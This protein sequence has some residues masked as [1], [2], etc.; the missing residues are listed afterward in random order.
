MSMQR[1]AL[2]ILVCAVGIAGLAFGARQSFGLFMV[3]V[4]ES[5]GWGRE[6]LSLVFAV[7]ALLNGL[8]A[9]F[10]GAV[11]DKWGTGRTVLTG[12][13]LYAAGLVVMSQA[14]SLSTR[15]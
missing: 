6:S 11:S 9:P 15:K 12:G 5:L 2:L 7:Q 1:L 10:A 4:S 13:A 3:P 8:G 14:A